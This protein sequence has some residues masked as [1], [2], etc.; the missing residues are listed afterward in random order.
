MQVVVQHGDVGG[1]EG[2]EG[3]DTLGRGEEVSA[4]DDD[5]RAPPASLLVTDGDQPGGLAWLA[6]PGIF[7]QSECP[8]LPTTNL[9]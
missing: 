6:G 9:P 4:G 5:G 8:Q 2:G 3:G 1:V 7:H